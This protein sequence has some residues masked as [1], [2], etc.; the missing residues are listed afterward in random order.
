VGAAVEIA[1]K[2]FTTED[3]EF[4]RGVSP[5]IAEASS[6]ADFLNEA[7]GGFDCYIP[8]VPV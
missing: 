2:G 5:K 6:G 7:C 4:H 3:T 1:S 8:E